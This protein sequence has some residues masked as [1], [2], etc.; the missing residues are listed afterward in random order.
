MTDLIIIIVTVLGLIIGIALFN[1]G[2]HWE[3]G[4]NPHRRKCKHCGFRQE[5]YGVVG[6]SGNMVSV[7]EGI[8]VPGTDYC[9]F[10]E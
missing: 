8:D 9:S 4:R 1:S 2:S 6:K 3:Y 10:H 7:W 5:E